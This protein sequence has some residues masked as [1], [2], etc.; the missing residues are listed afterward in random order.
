[1]KA[2]DFRKASKA[3]LV[4]TR[5]ATY[6]QVRAQIRELESRAEQSTADAR[7]VAEY[8]RRSRELELMTARL[9]EIDPNDCRDSAEA[10]L[11]DRD[12]E[13]FAALR[14]IAAFADYCD[15]KGNSKMAFELLHRVMMRVDW[16]AV[17]VSR[18]DEARKTYEGLL[19]RF[20]AA[21]GIPK[22]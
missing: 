10:I 17:K 18:K 16:A 7:T 9:K 22:P 5:T 2:S 15:E 14:S 19:Q 21:A 3:I 6:Q 20:A 13:P 11:A 1:V 12:A 8:K 4:S